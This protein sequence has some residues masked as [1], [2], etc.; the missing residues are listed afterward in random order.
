VSQ[1]LDGC[2]Q[3]KNAEG[4]KYE[5]QKTRP[6]TEK[7]NVYANSLRIHALCM[8][9]CLSV[10]LCAESTRVLGRGG[11]LYQVSLDP[12]VGLGSH[13][14]SKGISVSC[15]V[16]ESRVGP[17]PFFKTSCEHKL[18]QMCKE[19]ACVTEFNKYKTKSMEPNSSLE[20]TR[21]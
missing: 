15:S 5:V 8:L 3:Q 19:Q 18:H 20:I 16:E 17:S 13:I 10:C 4:L 7:G 9:V 21:G 1:I 12:V 14:C 11:G 6:L 2:G